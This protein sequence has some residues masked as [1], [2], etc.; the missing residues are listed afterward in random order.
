MYKTTDS[1]TGAFRVV[2]DDMWNGF[3][4]GVPM[5]YAE[6]KDDF[7]GFGASGE[8]WLITMVGAGSQ[9]VTDAVYGVLLCTNAGADNDNISLQAGGAAGESFKP[10]TGK[11]IYFET[12]FKCNLALEIDWAMGLWITDPTPLTSTDYIGFRKD[13]GT[14]SI[15]AVSART[16]VESIEAAIGTFANDAYIK[17]GFVV[18]GTTSVDYYINDILVATIN[19]N[20]TITELRPTIFMQ[21]GEAVAK[22][23]SVDYI[24]IAQER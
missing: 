15:G 1:D 22:T 18:N 7:F 17:L 13:D 11:K 2:S 9:A 24:Y 14:V 21:N 4:Y 23:L 8:Q 16:S 6:F 5:M 3:K 19:T 20:I 12:R 10:T